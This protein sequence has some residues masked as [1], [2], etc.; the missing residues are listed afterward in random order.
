MYAKATVTRA[1]L[2]VVA[3]TVVCT[4][5][6]GNLAAKDHYVT[7]AIHV[8]AQ[9]L[10]LTQPADAYTFYRRL[11]YAARVACTRGDQVALEPVEDLQG[12]IEQALGTAIRSAKTPL[13]TWIYL[14]AHTFQEA[15]RNGI[16]VPAQVAAK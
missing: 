8:S 4:L 10:D 11:Q 3:T 14:E 7:V 9:G 1:R 15:A 13:L 6:A 16:E 5:F 12:C 2:I